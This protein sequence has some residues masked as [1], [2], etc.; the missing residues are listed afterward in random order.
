MRADVYLAGSDDL[1]AWA[2]ENRIVLQVEGE[3]VRFAPIEYVIVYKLQYFRM[4]GS[5]RHLAERASKLDPTP[6]QQR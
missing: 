5:D 4:G 3:P 2:L 1:I 6:I